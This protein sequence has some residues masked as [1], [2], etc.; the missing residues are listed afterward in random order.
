[1]IYI[2]IY[3]AKNILDFGR[4]HI[5]I[6]PVVDALNRTLCVVIKAVDNILVYK[7]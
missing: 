5:I 4:F 2:Y 1:M 6:E 7:I 3:Y